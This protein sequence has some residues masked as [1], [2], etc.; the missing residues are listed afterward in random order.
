MLPDDLLKIV[1]LL[2]DREMRNLFKLFMSRE[3]S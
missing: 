3:Y 2:K 1:W